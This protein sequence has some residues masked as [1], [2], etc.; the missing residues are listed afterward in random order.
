MREASPL[1]F[2][3]YEGHIR[4]VVLLTVTNPSIS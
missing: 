2:S 3:R 4:V 1:S